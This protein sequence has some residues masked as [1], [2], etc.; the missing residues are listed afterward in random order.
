M[1][2]VQVCGQDDIR[3]VYRELIEINFPPH[4]RTL[5]ADFVEA[6]LSGQTLLF[7]IRD[8]TGW[9]GEISLELH[10][11]PLVELISWLSIAP[12]GRGLGIGGKLL[13]FAID[14]AYKRGTRWLVGEIENPGAAS[15]SAEHGDPSA[16]AKFYVRHRAKAIMA[17]YLQPPIAEGQDA[18][19]MLLIVFSAQ[20]LGQA[21]PSAPLK[22]FLAEYVGDYPPSWQRL[23]PALAASQVPLT[24]IS[25]ETFELTRRL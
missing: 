15:S 7:A 2:I 9:L 8:E 18:V 23:Q 22:E 21:I 24:D 20:P 6:V 12:A 16:R 5:E 14:Y 4:E 3:A 11:D 17:N 13:E 1:E 19:E 25:A 10:G